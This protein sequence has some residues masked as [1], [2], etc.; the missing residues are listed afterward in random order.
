M[1]N[2][3]I[4]KELNHKTKPHF[5]GPMVVV[6]HMKGGTYILAKLDGPVS[7]LSY[8]AFCFI[9]YLARFPDSI[10]VTSLLDETKL[11][12]LHVLAEGFPAADD[13]SDGL[14]FNEQLH[15]TAPFGLLNL[16]LMC[17]D[18]PIII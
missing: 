2:S 7:K 8:V 10:P 16:Y 18:M 17:S 3:C 13:P 11:E 12:D 4:K 6:H 15:P 14:D 5:L 1:H 9:H